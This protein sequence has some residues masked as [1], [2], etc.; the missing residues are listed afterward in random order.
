MKRWYLAMIGLMVMILVAPLYAEELKEITTEEQFEEFYSGY[1]Q[2][3]QVELVAQAITFIR[4]LGILDERPEIGFFLQGF[5]A[6]VFQAN[7]TR[8]ETWKSLWES[9]DD[10]L[11]SVLTSALA[12]AK[13]P[14]ATLKELPVAAE[15][16]DFC[17]GGFFASGDEIYLQTLVDRLK[18]LSQR[19]KLSLYLAGVT[20]G[21][22]LDSN[23]QKH[24]PIRDFLQKSLATV[25]PDVKEVIEGLL[26]G[27]REEFEEKT[28]SVIQA[29]FPGGYMG[30]VLDEIAEEQVKPLE[31]PGLSGVLVGKVKAGSP[32]AK[33][34]MQDFDVVC[35]F[36]GKTVQNLKGFLAAIRDEKPGQ[37]AALT[38]WRKGKPVSLEVTLGDAPK[39][40]KLDEAIEEFQEDPEAGIKALQKLG[41]E[42]E[43]SAWY[44]LGL[45]ASRG[46]HMDKSQE[47]AL[48][49]YR[50]S[51]ELGYAPGQHAVGYHL[52]NGEGCKRDVKAAADWY[53]KAAAQKHAGAAVM[54]AHVLDTE[55]ELANRCN[56]APRWFE[57]AAQQG[58][59]DAQYSL[60]VACV[61]GKGVKEDRVEA[62]KWYLLA[63]KANEPHDEDLKRNVEK[64]VKVLEVTL[65]DAQKKD[66]QERVSRFLPHRNY[67]EY[68]ESA[69]AIMGALQ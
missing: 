68:T 24:S 46:I 41:A 63:K 55:K 8:V 43:G 35:S 3:P 17:W 60:A 51:G 32:A 67:E 1:F 13:D 4:E 53:Q 31:L 22:S 2:K 33:A 23:A 54:L 7:P 57:I 19:E 34:G 48:E 25:D 56:E 66:A 11:K 64:M 42:G 20:A 49:F 58:L 69:L 40:G 26:Q 18:L 62:Y 52:F 65:D 28:Q 47:K 16:N 44:A 5:F 6:E 14:K 38:V 45:M 30:V 61:L 50:K 9:Q 29:S 59:S 36:A 21:W 12:A 15:S 39:P 27:K 10:S 37:K